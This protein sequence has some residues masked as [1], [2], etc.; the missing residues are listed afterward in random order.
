MVGL[1]FGVLSVV[2]SYVGLYF[3]QCRFGT[4]A[5]D[6]KCLPLLTAQL[7]FWGLVSSGVLVL[8]YGWKEQ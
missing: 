5:Y 8:M 4:E 7:L 3:L 2:L 6:I 1:G